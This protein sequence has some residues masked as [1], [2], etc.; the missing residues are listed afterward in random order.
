MR[1][2]MTWKEAWERKEDVKHFVERA[3]L[4]IPRRREQIEFIVQLIPRGR[5]APIRVLDLG[6]GQGTLAEAVLK[7]FP[8]SHVACLDGSTVMMKIGRERL[9][10]YQNRVSFVLE[11]LDNPSW[12][13]SIDGK[14]DAVVSSLAIHHLSDRRKKAL[15]REIWGITKDNGAL[16]IADLVKAESLFLGQRYER[17]LIETIRRQAKEI[18]GIKRTYE[19]VE[20]KHRAYEARSKGVDRPAPLKAQ[21]R[22][23]EQAG[24]VDVDCFWKYACFAIFGGFKKRK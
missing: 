4:V 15:F 23:L 21:L 20:A 18:A 7:A 6:A 19:E 13:K 3:D 5:S 12:L 11:E 10:K 24:F 9:G 22:W 8:N 2:R 14:F 1:K 16:I 17:M